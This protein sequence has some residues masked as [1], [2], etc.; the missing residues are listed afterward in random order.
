MGLFSK[1]QK[2]PAEK[3][4]LQFASTAALERALDGTDEWYERYFFA[5]Y[6]CSPDEQA[7]LNERRKEMRRAYPDKVTEVGRHFVLCGEPAFLVLSAYYQALVKAETL[8][9]DFRNY[10]QRRH[11]TIVDIHRKSQRL[12]VPIDLTEGQLSNDTELYFFACLALSNGQILRD[13]DS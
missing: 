11:D 7:E 9:E 3:S 12:P 13:S 1:K 6:H 8:P 2:K 10:A 5:L 4:R